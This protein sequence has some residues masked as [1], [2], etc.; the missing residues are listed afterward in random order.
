MPDRPAS[1]A[2]A[3]AALQAEL[4]HIGKDSAAVV[5]TKTGRTYGYK[6]AGLAAVSEALLPLMARLGLSFTCSPTMLDGQFVL[7]YVL[8][9]AGCDEK[10]EGWYPLPASS[11]QTIGGA[12]TYAR[13]YCLL[14]VTGAAPDE[15]DDDA[16]AAEDAAR[17]QR[18]RPPETR[19]DGSATDAELTRMAYGREPGT[20]RFTV[21][22]PDE[23]RWQGEP[24]EPLSPP[25]ED[26]PGSIGPQQKTRMFAMFA[27]LKMRDKAAQLAFIETVTGVQVGSRNDLSYRQAGDVLLALEE[28]GRA[29]V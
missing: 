17:A 7:E 9:L 3:L 25:A 20:E 16:Q 14:A 6:Y 1:L 11:P 29:K 5:E 27:G 22:P 12:I 26:A 2:A 21:P 24:G 13:R 15:D 28:A 10:V 4:P 19:A 18:R 23:D 8:R